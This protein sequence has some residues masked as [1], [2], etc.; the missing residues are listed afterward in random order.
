MDEMRIKLSVIWIVV[1]LIYLLGDVLRIFSG[2]VERMDGME[3]WTQPMWVG[4]AVLMLIPILMI[5]L[6]VTLDYPVNRWVNIGVAIFF[7]L[8]NLAGIGGY[9]S[10]YDKF[11][12]LVSMIF[13]GLTIWYAWHWVLQSG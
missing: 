11:L 13:N 9:P 8:F 7:L 6:S 1:M 3:Q 4:I 12:L 10:A 2:D 5:F